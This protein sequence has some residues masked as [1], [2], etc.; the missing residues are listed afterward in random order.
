MYIVI[1]GY[2]VIDNGITNGGRD[3]PVAIIRVDKI[4]IADKD[5]LKCVYMDYGT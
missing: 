4:F 2:E 3:F 1:T 5:T